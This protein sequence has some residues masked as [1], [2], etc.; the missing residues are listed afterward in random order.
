[1]TEKLKRVCKELLAS[2]RNLIAARVL[3]DKKRQ[4]YVLAVGELLKGPQDKKKIAEISEILSDTAKE[5]LEIS[6]MGGAT[7]FSGEN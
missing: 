7:K 5:T 4:E 1:M 6:L 2:Q 3:A